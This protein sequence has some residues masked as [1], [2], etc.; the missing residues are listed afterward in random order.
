MQDTTHD[1]PATDAPGV[2]GAELVPCARSSA[3]VPSSGAPCRKVADIHRGTATSDPPIA[4]NAQ[5]AA[6]SSW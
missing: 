1:Q 4:A 5:L 6:M 3:F 2:D